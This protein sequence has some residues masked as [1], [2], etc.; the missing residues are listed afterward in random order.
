MA[1]KHAS[2][3]SPLLSKATNPG[4]GRQAEGPGHGGREERR[5]QPGGK[6]TAGHLTTRRRGRHGRAEWG[7][8]P[9]SR[10]GQQSQPPPPPDR[11]QT[12]LMPPLGTHLPRYQE[13]GLKRGSAM[14]TKGRWEPTIAPG[15]CLGSPPQP[16]QA[17]EPLPTWARPGAAPWSAPRGL[18]A[19]WLTRGHLGSERR[20]PLGLPL[21]SSQDPAPARWGSGVEDSRGTRVFSPVDKR[22]V[23]LQIAHHTKKRRI[24]PRMR[25]SLPPARAGA[26][27]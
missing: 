22:R 5:G 8:S 2:H 7:P 4:N 12:R 19:G 3:P 13:P 1:Q 27:G 24:T 15:V 9:D 25:R 20:L 16:L 26:R 21:T 23:T 14:G 17:R 18:R 10:E 6:V 11:Q